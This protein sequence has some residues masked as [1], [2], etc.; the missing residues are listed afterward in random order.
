LGGLHSSYK[1]H[2]IIISRLLLAGIAMLLSNAAIAQNIFK[3]VL[4]NKTDSSAIAYAAIYLQE[5]NNSILTNDTGGFQFTIPKNIKEITL[6][7]YA[8]GI[9]TNLTYKTPFD[10]TERIYLDKTSNQLSE[11]AV[12]GLSAEEVVRMAVASIPLN[13]VDSSYFD[14]SFYRRYQKLNGRYVNLFE[15]YPVV[16]F[17]L[18]KNKHKIRSQEAFAVNEL[19]RSAYH[20]DIM[21]ALEDNPVDLLMLNPVYHLDSSSLNPVK[22]MS[23][24][25]SFDTT[26]KS[27]DYVIGYFCNDFSTDKHGIG[28]YDLRDMKGEEWETGE[29]VIDRASFAI[30]KISRK[31]RRH[32]DYHYIYFPPQ[33]NLTVYDHHKYFFEFI[34]GD[35]QV[36]Y[37]QHNGKWYLQEMHRQY[38]NEF[39][40][41]VFG[42]KEFTI[43]DFFEWYSDSTSRYTTKEYLDKFYQ[44]M[45]TAI[46]EYD[47]AFWKNERFPFHY[48]DKQTLYRDLLGDGPV[49][50]QFYDETKVDE[51]TKKPGKKKQHDIRLVGK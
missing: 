18:S 12:K 5:T 24:R 37:K 49:E 15:A 51:Y 10:K 17:R 19:R 11:V 38:S 29:L 1:T 43:T 44:K 46:H 42:T 34:D 14:Y 20:A 40:L 41:P 28:D 45:A 9:K 26:N 50:R 31:S 47:T 8:I 36:V 4:I 6:H 39:Y 48:A 22:F 2:L 35:M 23:Y 16:M 25:F 33:N 27:N 30:K 32:Q 7:I 21:N 3:G 13:Y